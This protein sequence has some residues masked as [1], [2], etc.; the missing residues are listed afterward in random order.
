[1]RR[2]KNK[3]LKSSLEGYWPGPIVLGERVV[4]KH[5]IETVNKNRDVLEKK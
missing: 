4:Q 3:K 2:V 5:I 1:M